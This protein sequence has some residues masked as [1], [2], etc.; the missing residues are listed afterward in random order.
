MISYYKVK[1]V[2]RYEGMI[3]VNLCYI[4]KSFTHLHLLREFVRNNVNLIEIK[5]IEDLK[6]EDFLIIS[7]EYN[8]YEE[9]AKKIPNILL[10]ENIYK[11]VYNYSLNRYFS[12]YDF[13]HL[14]YSLKK[15]LKPET[16]S[17]VVGSSYSLFGIEES[18]LNI[19][20]SI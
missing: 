14:K 1:F 13:Y 5:C 9:L 15:A 20:W 7:S 8:N 19:P 12:N 16:E 10:W 3:Y 2:I 17:I 11:D 4:E 6:C 18:M